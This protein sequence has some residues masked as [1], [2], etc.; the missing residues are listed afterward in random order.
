[1]ARKLLLDTDPSA[2][3]EH[4]VGLFTSALAGVAT[5]LWNIPKGF[6]SLGAELYDLAG[7]TDKAE[8]VEKWF[9]DVNPWD[10]EAEARTSGKIFQALAQIAPLGIGGYAM[11]A[12]YGSKLAR[13]LAGRANV[14]LK[15]A[16]G[17][18]RLEYR[19][20]DIAKRAIAAKRAGKSFSLNKFGSK[21]A[22]TG[23]GVVGGGVGEM[24]VAD[25][26]IGTLADMLQGTSLE[27]YAIT[28]MNRETK[29]GREEAYRRLMNRLKFGTEGALFNLAL[30]G[31]G[32]GIQKL[33]APSDKGIDEFSDH[34]LMRQFQKMFFGLKSSGYGTDIMLEGRML[35]QSSIDSI[36]FEAKEIAKKFDETKKE[37][38]DV[39]EKN[40]FAKKGKDMKPNQILTDQ[41]IIEEVNAILSPKM[42][43]NYIEQLHARAQRRGI[44]PKNKNYDSF[45]KEYLESD[46]NKS[47]LLG[48]AKRRGLAVTDARAVLKDSVERIDSIKNQIKKL[49]EVRPHLRFKDE[50]QNNIKQR[51]RLVNELKGLEEAKEI[52]KNDKG[53]IFKVKDYQVNRRLK[54]LLD[55]VK[56]SG[57][58][59][60]KLKDVIFNMR[61]VID[62]MSA[63]LLQS[64]MPEETAKSIRENIGGYLTKEYEK[65]TKIPLKKFKPTA[66][67]FKEA[68]ESRYKD[69]IHFYKQKK[70]PK[71]TDEIYKQAEQDVLN[72]SKTKSLD[73]A[74]L[75]DLGEKVGS[76]V[77]EI[78]SNVTKKE[79]ES[80]SINPKILEPQVLRPWQQIVAGQIKHPMWTFTSTVN[81][82]AHL[83][84]MSKYMDDMERVLSKGDNPAILTEEQIR[85]H[86]IHSKNRLNP[87]KWKKVENT[88]GKIGHGL[89]RLEGKYVKAPYYDELFGVT[90]NWINSSNV[91]TA[92]KYMILA[93]KG[94]AQISKTILSPLT[95]VRNFISA[96][97]FAAANGAFFPSYGD[98]KMLAPKFLGGEGLAR[99]AYE[100][101]GKRILGTMTKA[102]K[103]L[104]D[105]L[106]RTQ[107]VGTQV[108]AR[109]SLR[110]A[111][112]VLGNPH[113]TSQEIMG[114]YLNTGKFKTALQKTGWLYGKAQDAYIAE[115]D[116]WKIITWSLE[117]NRY[118]NILKQAGVN[119]DNFKNILRIGNIKEEINQLNKARSLMRTD[120]IDPAFTQRAIADNQNRVARLT[121][122]LD[123]QKGFEAVGDYLNR[124]VKR[125][126]NPVTREYAGN[127]EQ[128]LDEIAGN[129]VRNQVPNY[130]YVGRTARALRQ[131]P[132]GNFIAFPLEIIRTG[133]NI[134]EQGIKE[135]TMGKAI[136]A[137]GGGTALRNLGLRRIL[138]FGMTV[139][140]V[141]YAMTQTFKALH[142]VT[143]E[144]MEALRKFVPE[145][146]KNSTL[147]PTG[148][149]EDGYLKYVDFSYSNAYDVLTRPFRA[150]MN[151]LG[152]GNET[153][154][155]LMKALGT[156]TTDAMVELLEPFSSE[157]IFTEAL[158]D[159]TLRR[160]IGVGGRKVWSP[161]DDTFQKIRKGVGH[162]GASLM[163]GSYKQFKRIGQAVTGTPDEYGR[164]FNLEDEIHGL[165]GF[166]EIKSD[167]ERAMTYKST[168]FGSSLKQAENLFTSPLLRGGR[169]SPQDIVDQ[170]KYSESR[171][172]HVL[173]EIYQ[174]IEAARK[175]GMS[176]GK[177]RQKIQRKGLSK[178]VVNQLLRGTYTPKQPSSFFTRKIS[179]ITRD[180]N[181]KEGVNLPNPYYEALPTI[182][183]IISNNRNLNLLSDQ[184][185]IFEEEPGMAQGGRVG[186]EDGGEPGD[187]ALAANIW[188]TEPEQVKQAF[189]YDFEQYFASGV[190]MEKAQMQAPKQ[191]EPQASPQSPQVNANAIQDMKVNTN[192][193]QTGLTPTEH[194]LLSPE[195]QAIRLK[196]RGMGRA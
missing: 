55:Q 59:P 47:I 168:R 60:T 12:K 195:E 90:S 29:E 53:N 155:S 32:K 121:A 189:N 28:M 11:G 61:R 149:D 138:S 103:A 144:E 182:N 165:Y 116:F 41:K 114:T 117:R 35:G 10:D 98:I 36:N 147:L 79:I 158:I 82:Q 187:K 19:A 151:E 65:Y 73:E 80:V 58:D 75:Y 89:T 126:Y 129:M 1:M 62:N 100:L 26:D 85:A 102:D 31:A 45:V 18:A 180:L 191:P 39:M 96:G 152:T 179:E 177:I 93:P 94:V 64:G 109:E 156:G 131:S 145:W 50:L 154:D 139:G 172:F 84:Y 99:Q 48:S 44:I 118:D 6:V 95:H 3:S 81:R 125:N 184:L 23:M 76:D 68:T 134:L 88:D 49:D 170:Y 22:K 5:G 192:V 104:Y 97:A 167:P 37:I 143:E 185:N 77:R 110:I 52:V 42:Q 8:E 67:Q 40:V 153:E 132:Y 4:D 107:V 169:V 56:K 127:Y 24:F 27:P 141:P 123:K 20:A 2:K 196:Q 111:K 175:L 148:R 54:K 162:I 157:S 101:T 13:R 57:G 188:A 120:P 51:A 71:T 190:W 160:G 46:R 193:M 21:I 173:R 16:P 25:E 106:L 119:A 91:G 74:D 33:R 128:F 30:I 113:P 112:D 146:S 43:K 86:P 136:A 166:R 135:Y 140:G 115:D 63:R 171:R 34:W 15:G 105:R 183:N 87:N 38:L 164:T 142:D 17:A 150:V 14:A 181:Q 159:S 66:E 137:A 178:A 108:Q 122:E 130:A 9:D 124:S 163:P 92:Y 78:K 194:G 69:L 72:F 174:D 133:N 70:V 161:E 186:M 83:N 7:D 176:E